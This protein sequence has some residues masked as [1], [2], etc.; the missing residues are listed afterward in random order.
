MEIGDLVQIHL[1]IDK[2]KGVTPHDIGVIVA[3]DQQGE[4]HAW[5][6]YTVEFA[7]AFKTIDVSGWILRKI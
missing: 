3:I 7:M 2:Y 5:P 1:V 6:R 4:N